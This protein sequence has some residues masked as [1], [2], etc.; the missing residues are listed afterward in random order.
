VGRSHGRRSRFAVADRQETRPLECYYYRD[1]KGSYACAYGQSPSTAPSASER[2]ACCRAFANMR[3]SVTLSAHAASPPR[4]GAP[5]DSR[6]RATTVL[7]ATGF[8]PPNVTPCLTPT[9]HEPSRI[10]E[11]SLRAPLRL[12]FRMKSGE[13]A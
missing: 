10:W 5:I 1:R 12:V 9:E 7:L 4:P 11:S 3:T 6:P 2:P 13:N 8:V